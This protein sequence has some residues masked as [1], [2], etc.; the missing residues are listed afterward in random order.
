MNKNNVFGR[1]FKKTL[2]FK[3]CVFWINIQESNKNKVSNYWVALL[4]NCTNFCRKEVA[5][6]ARV[7]HEKYQVDLLLL[8]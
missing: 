8:T 3:H 1:C 2:F 6:F 7:K 5:N 4:S